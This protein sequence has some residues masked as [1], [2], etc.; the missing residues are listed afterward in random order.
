MPVSTKF[1]TGDTDYPTKLKQMDDDLNLG[2]GVLQTAVTDSAASAALAG[3]KVVLTNADVVTANA[4]V[5]SAQGQVTLA[6]NQVTLAVAAKD[7]A[8]AALDSFDDTYLGAKASDPTLDNDG[9]ALIVGA[10]YFN[11]SINKLKVYTTGLAWAA[12]QDGISSVAADT[13]PQLGGNLDLNNFDVP[14][15]PTQQAAI[16]NSIGLSIVFGGF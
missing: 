5:V 6:T 4:A 1:S 15:S 2:T 16:D 3:Q 13:S 14:I 9:N 8:E 10:Q 11:T 7:A 12:L